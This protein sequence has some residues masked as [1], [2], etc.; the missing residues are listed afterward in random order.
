[1]TA[2]VSLTV[3]R[4]WAIYQHFFAVQGR[5]LEGAPGP[6]VE[7][8]QLSDTDAH[9]PPHQR[10]GYYLS[11]SWGRASMGGTRWPSRFI[12]R[13]MVEGS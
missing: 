8:E 1:M 2:T 7:T 3:D 4:H 13:D 5:S 10:S 12:V 6:W 9:L 11:G